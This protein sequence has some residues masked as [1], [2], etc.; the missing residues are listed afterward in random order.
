LIIVVGA[1]PA[2]LAI[3]YELQRQALPFQIIEQGEVGESWRHHYDRLHLHTLKA[4]S[5]LP[6]LPM[7]AHYPDFPSGSQVH[8]YFQAY[9]T[10]FAFRVQTGVTVQAAT[11]QGTR[12]QLESSAGALSADVLVLTTGIWH[13]PFMPKL[14]GMETFGGAIIHSSRYRNADSFQGQRVLVVGA[15]NS[16]SEIALDLVAHGVETTIAIRSTASFVPYPS[17]AVAVRVA[18]WLL[19]YTPAPISEA[20]LRG[21]RRNYTAIG[22]PLPQTPLLDTYPVVGY[23]LPTAIGEGR[24]TRKRGI[25]ELTSNAVVFDDGTLCAFDA[26]ILATGYRPSLGFLT[27]GVTL[28]DRGRPHVDAQWRSLGQPRLFCVGYHYPANEG[29]LQSIG[30]RAKK[31]VAGI[32]KTCYRQP[33]SVSV[34]RQ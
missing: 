32:V 27:G 31:A 6:G 1:G 21:V 9:A 18:A 14:A 19:R 8:A 5:G 11:A 26:V 34:R 2:G 24:I 10:H 29:W 12:W 3:A 15:G 25:T 23:D 16:G 20:L 17:S 28:D 7:P 33:F 4:V 13:Q 22:L 30:R